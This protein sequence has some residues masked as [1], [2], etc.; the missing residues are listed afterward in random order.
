MKSKKTQLKAEEDK[1]E[2]KWFK[3]KVDKSCGGIKSIYDKQMERELLDTS[4]YLGN[5]LICQTHDGDLEGMLNLKKDIW[6]M[7]DYKCPPPKIEIGEVFASIKFKGGFKGGE[8]EQTVSLYNDFKRIDFE[9]K[10]NLK[11][12]GILLKVRFPLSL[13]NFKIYYET[14]Y[15]VIERDKG[16]FAAQNW[17]SCQGG[18]YGVALINTGNPGYWIEGNNL[19]LVL[20]WS[21]N[22]VR[23]PKSYDAPLAE[24]LGEH[25]FKY[26]LYPYQGDWQEAKVVQRGMEINNPLMGIVNQKCQGGSLPFSKSFVKVEPDNFIL[27]VLKKAEDG[28]DIILRGY[29]TQGKDSEVKIYLDFPIKEV[30]KTNL[31]EEREERLKLADNVISF[32]CKKF[33]IVTI[34]L[35]RD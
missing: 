6:G 24:E 2:N 19:D 26:S 14:P 12:S 28:N 16:H 1:L 11:E 13:R 15:A 27:T 21:V 29:E 35:R 10:I 17:V 33:E 25:I 31:L 22:Q 8:R 9:T 20:L 3:I 4:K 34:R 7:K 18:S 23:P 30:W 5:E 32:P